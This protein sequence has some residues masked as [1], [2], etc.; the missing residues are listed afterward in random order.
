[1][2]VI[3]L[4]RDAV[5]RLMEFQ[6]VCKWSTLLVYVHSFSFVFMYVY[7]PYACTEKT[8]FYD[9]VVINFLQTEHLERHVEGINA[10]SHLQE[11]NKQDKLRCV[12]TNVQFCEGSLLHLR[13]CECF[14]IDFHI[15]SQFVFCSRNYLPRSSCKVG[16]M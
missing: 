14:K 4:M 9:F 15:R 8:H 16:K 5:D 13:Y 2:M 10:F 1:M 7:L 12:A 11:A 3:Y 6:Y